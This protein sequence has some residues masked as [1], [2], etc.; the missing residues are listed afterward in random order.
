MADLKKILITPYFGKFPEWFHKFEPPQ[1][2]DWLLDV[3]LN[4]F[5]KRVKEKLGIEC[6]IVYGTGKLWDY[7]ATLGLLYEEELK[8]YDYYGHMDF[9]VCFGDV[10]K[11][12]PDEQINE[13]DVWSNHDKYICGFFS[14]YKNHRDVN[15]LF[16]NYPDWKEKL[17][18]PEPNGWV[19]NEFSRTL[20]QSGLRYKYS[21]FQGNPYDSNPSLKKE[22]GKL[23]QD[24][25]H[26]DMWEEIA[27]YHFRRSKIYPL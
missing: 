23:Y 20:E 26:L 11:W 18:Y 4:A 21:M 22:N 7:R 19:E 1:G 10:D 5:K 25:Q 9:D 15:N 17:I 14:L 3:N 27:M 6:P 13:L 12:F 2:Y 16:T 8:G 24:I